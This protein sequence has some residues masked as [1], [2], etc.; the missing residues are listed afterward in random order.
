MR[1]LFHR[2]PYAGR[3]GAAVILEGSGNASAVTCALGSRR[4]RLTVHGPGG[5]AWA[6]AGAPNPILILT[7]LLDQLAALDL[8]AAPRTVL[9]VGQ[10]AGGTS[11]NSIPEIASA[12]LDLRSTDAAQLEAIATKIQQL[13]A[14]SQQNTGQQHTL[15]T[16]GARPSAQLG[17][18][19]PILTTLH[20]VDRHL[21]LRTQ[22]HTASTDANIPMSLDIQAL[23]IGAGGS[24][25]GIHTLHEWYDPQNREIALRRILLLLLDIA[26]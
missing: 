10:I 1:H 9:N 16:I 18:H 22:A 24:G 14:I 7:R 25:G 5:H 6:D 19:A 12:L 23:A 8:P 17:A 11:V 13:T 26:R 4:F 20:A 3:F 21:N 2:S 15:E